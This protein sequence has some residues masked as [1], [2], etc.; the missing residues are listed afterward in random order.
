VWVPRPFVQLGYL[1][2]IIEGACFLFSSCFLFKRASHFRTTAMQPR[3]TRPPLPSSHWHLPPHAAVGSIAIMM[4]LGSL[5]S[6]ASVAA[7]GPGTATPTLTLTSPTQGMNATVG[8]PFPIAWRVANMSSEVTLGA[9]LSLVVVSCPNSAVEVRKS[10]MRMGMRGRVAWGGE[11]EGDPAQPA[12]CWVGGFCFVRS[13]HT[14]TLSAA[15]TPPS[16][17]GP[18]RHGTPWPHSLPSVS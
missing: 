16:R 1:V 4:A 3:G 18:P 8:E 12:E 2:R 17:P 14:L 15:H 11:G 5:V 9:Q 13:S 6:V 7:S 10:S